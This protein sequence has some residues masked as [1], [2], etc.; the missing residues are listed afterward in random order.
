MSNL[1]HPKQPGGW[2]EAL[3]ILMNQQFAVYPDITSTGSNPIPTSA[4]MVQCHNHRDTDSHRLLIIT[5]RRS[6]VGRDSA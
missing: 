1:V 5:H 4:G 2:G 3:L 6:S